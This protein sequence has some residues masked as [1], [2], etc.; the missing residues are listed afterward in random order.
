MRSGAKLTLAARWRS[1]AVLTLLGL[2]ALVLGLA[3]GC[4]K[5][6]APSQTGTSA[7]TRGGVLRYAS[8][9]SVNIDPAVASTGP[10]YQVV[11]LVYNY[12]VR[13]G[14]DFKLQPE[15]ATSW[16]TPDGKTWTFELRKGV[17]FHDGHDFTSAD[18]IYT[19]NRLKNPKTG[20]PVQ[21][22][23]TN[24]AS[25]KAVDDYTVVI[26][27]KKVNGEFG[28]NLTQFQAAM[29]P[30]G[31]NSKSKPDGTGPFE[32]VSLVPDTRMVLEAN[33]HYWRKG[34][35]GEKLP[36]LAGVEIDYIPQIVGQ[37]EAARGGEV[38][39][40][41]GISYEEVQACKNDPAVKILTVVTNQHYS[42][43]MRCDR[44]PSKDPRVRLALRLG[45]DTVTL[46]KVCRPGGLAT[47]GNGT[48]VGPMYTAFYLNQPPP[49][50]PK[51][52]KELLAEAGYA[53]GLSITVQVQDAWGCPEMATVWK[54]MMKKIGVNVS[55]NVVPTDVY[56]GTGPNNW[57]DCDYGITDWGSRASPLMYFSIEYVTGAPWSGSKWSDPAF[58]ALCA[59]VEATVDDQER[60]NL[61]RQAQR[62]LL[63]SQPVIILYF[64]KVACIT[65][66]K[67]HNVTLNPE[68][69]MTPFDE[70]WM[71]R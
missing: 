6:S 8:S 68:W 26:N 39:F 45:T 31:F 60:A 56:Y 15:L 19:F 61:Y 35:N 70:V 28:L 27:L 21:S 42:I 46:A 10:D 1:V 63:A 29:E 54:A 64:E 23:F 30:V 67:L 14:P 36:Y 65:S 24:I 20:S 22:A 25:M 71:S 53:H 41:G 17:V 48:L 62:M 18:V 40:V 69:D 11:G 2:T 43:H 37:V 50:D 4:G 13:L 34:P 49:Y 58:D 51:K 3:V 57:L 38:D 12:L 59:K 47:A 32:Y 66:A 52:A 33:P 7:V 5:E 55:I 16:K 44:G 9:P